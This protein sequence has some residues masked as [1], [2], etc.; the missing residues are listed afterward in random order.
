MSASKWSLR[1][2]VIVTATAV[3]LG[4]TGGESTAA[5]PSQLTTSQIRA[6][7]LTADQ[8]AAAASVTSLHADAQNSLG[9]GRQRGANWCQRAYRSSASGL[10]PSAVSVWSFPTAKKAKGF[11][12]QV[13]NDR[14]NYFTVVVSAN[15]R[16]V[17]TTM[18]GGDAGLPT[19]S[20]SV[21]MVRGVNVVGAVCERAARTDA[22]TALVACAR[23]VALAQTGRLR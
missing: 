11:L 15:D 8:A 5:G 2:G 1:A 14:T 3:A 12:A 7:L 20:G 4:A 19:D 22:K 18:D 9:C 13:A 10:S 23:Q 21:F 16:L 17:V 6:A